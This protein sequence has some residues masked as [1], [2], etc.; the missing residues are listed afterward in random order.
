MLFF[1]NPSLR[2]GCYYVRPEQGQGAAQMAHISSIAIGV[3]HA[4]M[5]LNW[6]IILRKALELPLLDTIEVRLHGRRDTLRTSYAGFDH[7]LLVAAES[8]GRLR[9]FFS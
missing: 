7:K 3:Y 9:L 2:F 1:K 5:Q 6:N 4:D 8:Q